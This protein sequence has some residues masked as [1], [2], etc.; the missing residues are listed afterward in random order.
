MIEQIV[1][2]YRRHLFN[3]P[4]SIIEKLNY[5]R[6]L[7]NKGFFGLKVEELETLKR[8]IDRFFNVNLAFFADTYPTKLFRVTNNKFLCEG[9]KEKLQKISQLLGPP[10]GMS[11]YNRCNLP[12]ESVF[13][14]ALNLETALWE[15]QPQVGDYI[16][17]SEWKIKPGQ[18]LNTHSIFHPEKTFLNQESKNAFSYY[19]EAQKNIDPN[20]GKIFHEVLKFLTEEFM[21]IVSSDEKEN[22]LFSAFI[23]SRF[24]QAAP[25]SNGFK[26][27]AISYPSTKMDF[28]LTNLAIRNSI[29]LDK[30]QLDSILVFTVG[31]TNYDKANIKSKDI[32]KTG[33][34]YEVKDFDIKNDKILYN[35]EI[36]LKL[37]MEA[38]RKSDDEK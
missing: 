3:S 19:K 23:S 26:I 20:F 21:K 1:K 8:N 28:G 17:V 30:L 5:Y 25:D 37:F 10:V 12:G 16:T 6:Q 27:D 24:L 11:N 15:T 4:E 18:F 13:Y 29:V 36:E 38:I 7:S 33:F 22:Y 34:V 2:D 31:E 35:P 32:I 9:R 14:A